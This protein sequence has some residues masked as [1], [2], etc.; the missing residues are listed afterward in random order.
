MDES[1]HQIKYTTMTTIINKHQE[2]SSSEEYTVGYGDR[3]PEYTGPGLIV[4]DT[5]QALGITHKNQEYKHG[6]DT[7][8]FGGGQ[9]GAKAFLKVLEEA[10]LDPVDDYVRVFRDMG[11]DINSDYPARW[12]YVWVNAEIMIA[13]TN[14]P[15]S[16]DKCSRN[17]S[18]NGQGHAGTIGVAGHRDIAKA[19]ATMIS[20][21][22]PKTK[23]ENPGELF[24]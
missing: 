13:T 10:G 9:V 24:Y 7:T 6:F 3:F 22:V 4:K 8:T 1:P 23:G 15:I 18:D 21:T 16:G 12:I 5:N 14:N 2:V 19:V 20:D 11:R 17:H